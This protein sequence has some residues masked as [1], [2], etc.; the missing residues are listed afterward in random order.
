MESDR[1]PSGDPACAVG[2]VKE[3]ADEAKI[4][5][6]AMRKA[7]TCTSLPASEES[8]IPETAAHQL[9]RKPM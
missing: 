6:L 2:C 1:T 7:S 5:D 3:S 9:D 4:E 8:D